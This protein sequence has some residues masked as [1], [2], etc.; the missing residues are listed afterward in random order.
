MK[1][2]IWLTIIPIIILIV[3]YKTQRENLNLTFK[4]NYINP[5]VIKD[6]TK[7]NGLNIT[8]IKK[9]GNILAFY[10]L[11]LNEIIT[12]N[13]ISNTEKKYGGMGSDSGKF[14]LVIGMDM[15]TSN[16]YLLDPRNKR[17]TIIN[18]RT[19]EQ[20]YNSLH[21][22]ERGITLSNTT[23]LLNVFNN[24]SNDLNF[25]KSSFSLNNFDTLNFPL[26]I[27]GDG[28]FA[29]DGFYKK[30]LKGTVVFTLY[31]LG[32]FVCLDT[33]GSIKYLGTT[34]DNYT[35]LPITVQTGSSFVI[36][37]KSVSVNKS[38]ALNSKYIFILSNLKSTADNIK[39]PFANDFIDVYS[40][41]DGKYLY[42][43]PLL[44]LKTSINDLE[45][46]ENELYIL[47]DNMVKTIKIN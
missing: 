21:S 33:S 13:S 24:N 2:I 30:N 20:M 43:Y 16:L 26:Q 5:I 19:H 31:H 25:I 9:Y 8:R 12:L 35:K 42:S 27:V 14:N 15:D 11:K 3:L 28:A 34:I 1:K 32:K 4:R 18:Y 23:I 44:N 37:K 39:Y 22:F 29:N 46:D 41:T 36:S 45:A 17:Q 38:S 10:D 40:I 47:T 7:V 6:L